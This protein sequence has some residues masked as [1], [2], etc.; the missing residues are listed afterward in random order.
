MPKISVSRGS[1]ARERHVF[2]DGV[3]GWAALVVVLYHILHCFLGT[4]NPDYAGMALRFISDGALAVYVFF[5][6]SGFALSIGFVQS[7]DRN[8]VVVSALRRYVRLAVPIF[9]S[10]FLAYVVLSAGLMFNREA[11]ALLNNAEWVGSFYPFPPRLTG[12]LHFSLY[13]VFFDFH[14]SDIYNAVLW[15]METE[16][17]GSAVVFAVLYG[18]GRWK[19]RWVLYGGV[20]AVLFRG[21]SPF[22]AFVWG[23]ILADLSQA[24]P[25]RRLRLRPAGTVLGAA[26]LFAG[27]SK[28]T[29][30]PEQ[31]NSPA[32]LSVVALLMVTSTIVSGR[33]ARMFE[34][35]LSV[36]LGHLSFPVYLTHLIVI[37]SFSSYIYTVLSHAGYS[38]AVCTHGTALATFLVCIPV[39][40]AFVPVERCAVA[41]SQAFSGAV[42]RAVRGSFPGQVRK[43]SLNER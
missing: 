29:W 33:I 20:G 39:A 38:L 28:S 25:V 13:G 34:T 35:S 15:T 19:Y 21:N 23:L 42:V 1:P 30:L 27:F 37:C 14:H 3:R 32:E 16:L 18:V 4:V 43:F 7:G 36:F 41:A 31:F 12:L 10:S 22:A 5:V 2:I 26:L 9:A 6:L 24:A 40:L 11:G 8:V 17:Y